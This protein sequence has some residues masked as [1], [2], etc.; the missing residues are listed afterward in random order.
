MLNEILLYGPIYSYSAQ[1]FFFNFNASLDAGAEKRTVRVNTEGGEPNYGWGMIAKIL[2]NAETTAVKV[3]AMAYS[4]GAFA[5]CYVDDVECLDVTEFLIHRAAYPDWYEDSAYFTEAEKGSLVNMNKKLEAAF[6]AKVDVEKFE[7]L[8]DVKVKDIFS[9][10]SRIDVYLTAKEAKAIGLVS[11]IVKITPTKKAEINTMMKPFDLKAAAL[12]LKKVSKNKP[13]LFDEDEEVDDE[14]T[15]TKKT[16]KTLAELK[17]Q[18]PTLYAEAV[19]AGAKEAREAEHERIAA[20][21][22]FNDIDAEAVKKGIE[23]GKP[24]SM[25]DI[26]EF[27][28]KGMSANALASVKKDSKSNI[29]TEEVTEEAKTKNVALFEAEVMSNLGLKKTA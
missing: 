1:D 19:A 2:E 15:P 14:P 23:S 18:N 16:M 25:K 29:V 21:M 27:T 9:M 11:R 13:S 12:G 5:C 7:Q 6:R 22:E 8:K 3:D 24:M 28:R 26:A 10:E 20:W 17:D 4:F